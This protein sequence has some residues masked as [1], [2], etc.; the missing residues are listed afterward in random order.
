[1][2]LTCG[3]QGGY[4]SG[5]ARSAPNDAAK[6][7]YGEQFPDPNSASLKFSFQELRMIRIVFS[8]IL[9]SLCLLTQIAC[10]TANSVPSTTV[11]PAPVASATPVALQYEDLVAGDGRRAAWGAV[12]TVKYVG[13]LTDGTTVD[14]GKF[15]FTV[16]DK[17]L[18]K[19]FNY[20]IGGVEDIPAMKVGGKRKVVLPPELA[21]GADGD[22]K[23][24]P[25]NATITFEL[26]LLRV[27]GGLGF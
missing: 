7:S 14:E 27:Q 24:I 25:P 20:G 1:V 21:Y 2:V 10:Q 5:S 6:F 8:A 26:E 22:G 9:L 18:I 15:D 12:A 3:G 13:K 4:D 17:N 16:G 23:K 11:S 19:G